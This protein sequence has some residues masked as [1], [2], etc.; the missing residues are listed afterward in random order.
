VLAQVADTQAVDAQAADAQSVDLVPPAPVPVRPGFPTLLDAAGGDDA[1]FT[2]LL[3]DSHDDLSEGVQ[4]LKDSLHR[5]DLPTAA[6]AAHSLKSVAGL[7]DL[8]AF[9]GFCA[10]VQDAADGGDL[11]EAV[12]AFLPLHAASREA[13][14]AIGVSL[15]ATENEPIMGP[16]LAG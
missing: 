13:L 5:D 11:V 3:R 2:D 9:A 4:T 15:A 10:D 8:G 6:R 12:E 16:A 7:L 1:L 14:E